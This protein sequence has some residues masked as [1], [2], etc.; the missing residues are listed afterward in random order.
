MGYERKIRKIDPASPV[1]C[2]TSRSSISPPFSS[3]D[4]P[5]RD[6]IQRLRE[7]YS[8]YFWFL[9]Y[10][11]MGNLLDSNWSS[12]WPASPGKRAAIISK[13]DHDRFGR[14]AGFAGTARV[15]GLQ[16]R[17]GTRTIRP[18]RTNNLARRPVPHRPRAVYA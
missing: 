11:L 6:S 13:S 5:A 2:K 1:M 12:F 16:R 15:G 10:L 8:V 14:R 17:M 4:P 7:N 3:V 18:K 9:Q